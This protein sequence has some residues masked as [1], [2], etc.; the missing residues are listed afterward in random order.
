MTEHPLKARLI[1]IFGEPKRPSVITEIQFDFDQDELRQLVRAPWGEAKQHEFI[2]YLHDLNY[3][4]LQPDLFRY[5]FP[6]LLITLWRGMADRSG[7][8][9]GFYGSVTSG[10]ALERMLNE[11]ERAAVLTWMVDAFIDAI[12]SPSP[13]TWAERQM[14][15]GREYSMSLSFFNAL[16]CSFA[17]TGRIW[18]QLCNVR[19]VGR[20]QW[21]TA[22][23]AGLMGIDV[24]SPILGRA[25]MDKIGLYG[26]DSWESDPAYLPV[27]VAFMR[28]SVTLDHV[29]ELLDA[30]EP[31]V[32]TSA[33]APLLTEVRQKILAERQS[34]K[35]A[36]EEYL[37]RLALPNLRDESR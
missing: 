9:Q 12:D 30:S 33:F 1:E 3:V 6:S 32:A 15:D 27:N 13:G 34:A 21:W 23:G 14:P 22:V 19:T 31:V 10:E 7:G 17:I 18:D 37:R 5:L 36:I 35:A 20:G 2:G 26:T 28:R 25:L 4:E 16:G 24:P 11:P 29:V 8:P